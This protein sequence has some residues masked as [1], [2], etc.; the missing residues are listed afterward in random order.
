MPTIYDVNGKTPTA[1]WIP[2]LD[3]AGNGTTTLTDLVGTRHGTLTNFALSGST[4]NWVAENN[5][6]G[7]YALALDGLNDF[8]VAGNPLVTSAG[9]VSLWL[10]ATSLAT[11]ANVFAFS[12]INS[13]NRVYIN[14]NNIAGRVNTIGMGNTQGL[15]TSPMSLNT[16]YCITLSYN[17]S[18]ASM[19]V[20][21]VQVGSATAYT[22]LTAMAATINLGRV[23]AGGG[24]GYFNGLIDDVRTFNVATDLADHQ[25][26]YN[27]NTGRGRVATALVSSIL[28]NW[29]E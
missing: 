24:V 21:G 2:S 9:S 16:W 5:S 19:F 14:P 23:N 7:A 13:G 4:S 17:G 18:T 22:G 1:A 20:N 27:A 29:I 28:S 15:I 26:L 3:T 12:H 10:N 6:G 25:Y 11:G 8:V